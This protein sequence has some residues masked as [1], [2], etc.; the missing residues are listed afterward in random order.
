MPRKSSQEELTGSVKSCFANCLGLKSGQICNVDYKTGGSPD[1]D[2]AVT[3][4]FQQ[5][6]RV[7]DQKIM[8]CTLH[9][10]SNEYRRIRTMV[11]L[12]LC[13]HFTFGSWYSYNSTENKLYP[14]RNFIIRERPGKEYAQQRRGI[15]SIM[16]FGSLKS[17]E[18]SNVAADPNSRMKL[19][20]QMI[21][22]MEEEKFDGL[23][24]DWR[25]SACPDSDCSKGKRRDKENLVTLMRELFPM[26][27]ERGK[28]LLLLLPSPDKIL[29]AGYDL[30]ALWNSV[31]YFYIYTHG[32]TGLWNNY[33]DYPTTQYYIGGTVNSLKGRIGLAKMRK[34][35]GGFAPQVILYALEKPNP[36]PAFRDSI[37]KDRSYYANMSELCQ[38]VQSENYKIVLDDL[39]NN[40]AHNTTHAY[41][42]EDYN[43][44]KEKINL[45]KAS[46]VGGLVVGELLAD[47]EINKCGRGPMPIL[48]IASEL[49]HGTSC[50]IK[51][52]VN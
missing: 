4:P 31:D 35:L 34:V 38:K 10:N 45:F 37:K 16:V 12:N 47:D 11:D 3:R 39:K 15:K 13:T 21:Q 20:D 22:I 2:C 49:F 27:K 36:K 17:D 42:Y 28:L 14:K 32:Y 24:V 52:C 5:T 8:L 46:G 7:S 43:T 29:D 50:I 40:C 1:E 9:K 26:T 48:R 6:F 30:K 51:Q 18:W 33:F 44:L 19:I 25:F 41:V 23:G